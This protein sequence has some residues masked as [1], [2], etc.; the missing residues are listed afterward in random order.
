MFQKLLLLTFLLFFTTL[1]FGQTNDVILADQYYRNGAYDKALLIYQN[2]YNSKTGKAIFYSGYLK[3]L[4]KLK[5]YDDAEKLIKKTINENPEEYKFLLDYGK[6]LKEK[7]LQQ[8]ADEIFNTVIQK[9]PADAFVVTEIAGSFYQI[10]NYDFAIK[11]FLNGRKNLKDETLFTMELVN[12]YRFKRDKIGL[13]EELITL[14]SY[15]TEYLQLA[16]NNLAR[17]YETAADYLYLKTSLLKKIQKDAENTALVDLLAWQFIQQKEFD[18]ALIQVIALDKRLKEDGARV[19]ILAGVFAENKAYDVSNKAYEYVISKGKDQV[20]YIASRVEI[21]KNKN[22]VIL[23]G[24]FAK[25]DLQSLETDYQKLVDE[26]GKNNRTVFALRQLANLKAFYLN[27]LS[28]AQT[29]LEEVVQ[30]AGIS[31]QTQAET[32]LDLG[33]IYILNN[34]IWEAALLYGQVEKSFKNEPL[35]QEAKFRNAKLSFYNGDFKWAKAQL[36]VLKAS[37]SQLIANDALNL[38]LLIQDH[39]A[40]D[41]VGNA[42]KIYATADLY[43]FKNQFDKAL[44]ILDSINIVYPKNDLEDD[45]LMSQT[46]IYLK[47]NQTEKAVANLQ[48]IIRNHLYGIWAD[49]ALF[50][51]AQ[52]QEEKLNL[53]TEAKQNFEKLITD[54]PG[55]L[56]VIE[57]RKRFRNLRGDAL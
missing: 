10:E 48:N 34:D 2:L 6:L 41:S 53:K 51:L 26:Y 3:T 43:I 46:K 9:M 16:K 8:K 7:G 17:V 49:D 35:G 30:I 56:F 21:L 31:S 28:E 33:D 39:L 52:L 20:Y 4:L 50:M 54:F 42:L 55:S 40:I 27:K 12:L 29:I 19:F 37:T 15:N 36:D 38:S 14:L 13:T 1:L 32:K 47:L 44:S 25:A 5:K 11:T 23:D 57:A 22:Q 45:I 24:T 18:M